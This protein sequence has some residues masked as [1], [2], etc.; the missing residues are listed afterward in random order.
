MIAR[1]G[2]AVNQAPA[3]GNQYNASSVFGAAITL[4]LGNFVVYAGSGSNSF[5]QLPALHGRTNLSF[6]C[7]R[8][9]GSGGSTDYLLSGAPTGS[10]TATGASV[11]VSRTTRHFV[12]DKRNP[13]S[14][15]RTELCLVACEWTFRHYR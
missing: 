13:D 15:R 4:G 3:D 6:R 7:F 14:Q 11:N 8:Y 5:F 10:E 2:N 12:P 1:S 9:N